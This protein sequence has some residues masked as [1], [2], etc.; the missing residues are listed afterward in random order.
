MKTTQQKKQNLSCYNRILKQNIRLAKKQYYHSC[1]LKF[2]DDIKKT[3]SCINEIMNR[4]KKKKELP[5]QFLVNNNY[6]TNPIT[7]SNGFNNFFINIGKTL[8][9]TIHQP[10]NRSFE[11]F[12]ENSQSEIFKFHLQ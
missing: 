5:K 4:T 8:S 12:L 11:E 2:K 9:E 3:W 6:I 7:I 10:L 1:F